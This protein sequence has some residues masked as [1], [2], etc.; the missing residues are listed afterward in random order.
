MFVTLIRLLC[1]K[2]SSIFLIIFLLILRPATAQ[3]RQIYTDANP[4]NYIA[5]LSFYA[6]NEGYAAFRDFLGYTTDSGRTFQKRSITLSNVD[7]NGYSPNLTF[8]FGISGIKAFDRNTL[9]VYGDY[10]LV[11]SVLYTTDGGNTFKLI[12]HSQYN[13]LQLST[14]VLD[15]VFPQ[16]DNIGFA[17]DADRILKTSDKG[18]TWTA[19]RTDP[20]SFFSRLE[21]IDD[22][23]VFAYNT[24]YNGPKLLR[25]LDGGNSWQQLSIP[26]G[27]IRCASFISANNGWI[28]V[29]PNGSA[30]IVYYTSNG[31]TSWS[32]KNNTLD[33]SFDKIKFL[34]DSTGFGDYGFSVYKTTDSGKVWEP[35]A[36][37]NSYSYVNYG[38]DDMQVLGTQLWAGGVH[39]FLQLGTQLGGT[40]LPTAYLRID[41]TNYAFTGI[42]HGINQSKPTYQYKWFVNNVLVSQNFNLAYTHSNYPLLDTIR[43]EVTDGVHSNT[44]LAYQNFNPPLIVSSFDPAKG[45][46]GTTVT[47]RGSNFDGTNYVSFGGTPAVVRFISDTLIIATVTSGASGNVVVASPS[48]RGSLPGFTFIPP[49][50]IT[51]FSPGTAKAG[52]A[53]T[54]TGTNFTDASVVTFGGTQ[55][56]SFNVISPTEIV[57]YPSSGSSGFI[58]VATAGGTVAS[59]TAFV[60]IPVITSFTPTHGTS[61]TILT[62]SGTGLNG[63]TAISVGGSAVRSDTLSSSIKIIAVLGQGGTGDVKV[64]TPGGTATLAG[65]TYFPPSVITSFTPVSGPIGT[66]VTITGSNFSAVPANNKVYFGNVPASVVAASTT[67]LTINVPAGA[68]FQ[69]I[70][71]TTNTYTAYSLYPFLVTFPNGGSL[72]TRSFADPVTFLTGAESRGYSDPAEVAVGDLDGDGKPDVASANLVGSSITILRNTSSQGT[73]SFDARQDISVGIAKEVSTITMADFDGDGKLDIAVGYQVDGKLSVMRNTSTPGSISFEPLVDLISANSPMGIIPIDIDGDGRPDIVTSNYP[74]ATI[75]V[76]LNK[77]EAGTIAFNGKADFTIVT[78]LRVAI[79]DIDG[80]RKSDLIFADIMQNRIAVVRNTSTNGNV[81]FAPS[82]DL[83]YTYPYDVVTGDIDGDGKPDITTVGP[84]GNIV[85]FFRNTSTGTIS[86]DKRIDLPAAG[87]PTRIRLNDLDGDGKLDIM[88]LG[89][90]ESKIILYKNTGRPGSPSFSDRIYF[91]DSLPTSVLASADMD[92]DG[93]N[94]LIAGNTIGLRIYLNKVVAEP[95][96]RSFTPLTG[97]TGGTIVITGNNFTGTTAVSFGGTPAQSYIVNSD[98][99]IS[100]ILA[101]GATGDVTVA[102]GLGQNSKAG[103]TYGLVPVITSF[104]PLS[105]PVGTT[106]TII[107]SN[108]SPDD[109]DNVVTIGGIKATILSSTGQSITATVPAGIT[110]APITVTTRHLT[111]YS[112]T[113][114]NTIFPGAGPSFT[115]QTFGPRQDFPGGG[116][117]SIADLDGDG[118]LD[119]VCISGDNQVSISRNTSFPGTISFDAPINIPTGPTPAKQAYADL[120]GDGKLDMVTA[121]S[122]NNSLSI[123]RNTGS[124]GTLSFTSATVLSSVYADFNNTNSIAIDDL[125]GDGRPDI[126]VANYDHV[127]SIFHNTTVNGTITFVRQD[128]EAGGY[129]TAVTIVDLDNDGKKDIAL[130]VNLTP[131]AVAVFRNISQPGAIIMDTR[132]D[133]VIT[134]NWPG[135]IKAV[136][137]DGDGK[138]DLLIS[139]VNGNL[140]T[141]LQN[142]S[143]PG[144]I[145][146]AVQKDFPAG[147]SPYIL[148]LGDLDGDGKVDLGINSSFIDYYS[149]NRSIYIAKNN[150]VA[151]APNIQPKLDYALHTGTNPFGCAVGDIDGDGKPDLISFGNFNSVFRNQV[152]ES[153]V[154]AFTPDTGTT[155]TTV[156]ISGIGFTSTTGVTFGG[157]A[158]SSFTILS[159]TSMT[160]IVGAG[161]SG[162][163]TVKRTADTISLE[164]FT[165]IPTPPEPTITVNGPLQ[166][167]QG[168]FDTLRSSSLNGNQWYKDGIA[169]NDTI[170]TLVTGDPG[171]YSVIVTLAGIHSLSSASVSL[172][173][174]PVPAKPTITANATE[175]IS[176]AG[177]GNQWY[178]DT[179]TIIP[180]A[181]NQRYTPTEQGQYSA[182]VTENGCPGPF[183]DPYSFTPLNP[184]PVDSADHSLQLAPNPTTDYIKITFSYAGETTVSVAIADFNGQV[185]MT[186]DNVKSGDRI[187]VADLAKGY[188]SLKV[189]TTDGKVHVARQFGKW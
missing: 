53:I 44:A 83:P 52:D 96:I 30:G 27:Q 20:G 1:G 104:S 51:A 141:M 91:T 16:N 174:N 163:V 10:G 36:R 65:F 109:P 125:D 136:D 89:V 156:K 128:Y 64:N 168:R 57:A 130:S 133:I 67:A 72:T 131:V 164:G 21:A 124:P 48:S 135:D 143:I 54:I 160:A 144:S 112:Q 84:E 93:K 162:N 15:M 99:S 158:A 102:N 70:S 46:G 2:R 8:G 101:A 110:W 120:D 43:L 97:V 75:S 108:F 26:A 152:G 181:T 28:Q 118:K 9:V 71:V 155:G 74:D 37:D 81:S 127:L 106:I 183:S 7:Y 76:Y 22:N 62:I 3:L 58:T 107:G 18:R 113:A 142:K 80:D 151:G 31:G 150:S 12:F 90:S 153:S 45:G 188:Y 147:D 23:T 166:F 177:L 185:L 50:T 115:S 59:T 39:G 176:S 82:Y 148:S 33:P 126:V 138:P 49:P 66:R 186:F 129:P 117:G 114:F 187:S 165:F 123:F 4:D 116:Y 68:T 42:V 29:S 17:V 121:N 87:G 77:S 78:G 6:P 137:W 55:A 146:F 132:M 140:L 73:L 182:R 19:A 24:Q 161:A 60:E 139:Q 41:T 13:P 40:P 170:A 149:T 172:V 5:K 167:C 95:F 35:L 159:D 122:K 105:G 61:G 88:A 175:L 178:V 32:I 85:S 98:T 169:I 38:L 34:D 184:T 171:S 63:A 189:T 179:T 11:P 86:F 69:P 94:D 56:Y 111:A 154:T 180:G 25:T 47:I 119:L 79:A 92:G 103:F 100:A 157:V 173:V 145:S 14:G 134:G